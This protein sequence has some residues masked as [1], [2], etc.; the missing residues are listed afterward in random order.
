MQGSKLVELGDDETVLRSLQG[1]NAD[2]DGEGGLAEPVGTDG[3]LGGTGG[4]AELAVGV[5]EVDDQFVV[6]R[7][8]SEV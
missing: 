8:C 6:N 3:G 7:V 1:V 2:G 4:G 5:I